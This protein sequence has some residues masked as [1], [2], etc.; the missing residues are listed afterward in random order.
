MNKIQNIKVL[1]WDIDNTLLD[2]VAGAEDSMKQA[3]A[4]LGLEFKPEM[5]NVFQE[6]NH[7]IWDK[8]E[9]GELSREDLPYVRWQIILKR[10]GL[11]ADGVA[12]EHVFRSYLHNSAVPVS[13]ALETLEALAGKYIFCAASNGP[14]EQQLNRLE[15]GGMRK[16]FTHCFVS[17][18]V[19]V[20]KPSLR[21][22]EKCM[23]ELPGI[24]PEE[25]LMIGDSLTADIAGGHAA[26]L[27]TCWYH[28]EDAIT[29]E[30]LRELEQ[31][32][33]YRV[34]K[35]VDLTKKL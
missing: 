28:P 14:Y 22:F 20:E 27:K 34:E 33:D 30:K 13:G 3:F 8:I 17:E 32:A 5:F 15:R 24:E 29:N 26:G 9:K 4:D 35:L 25:C 1:F 6:E 2:F 23:E 18:K 19:G 12:M 21:F 7:I 31:Q 10:L 16:Y 11:K